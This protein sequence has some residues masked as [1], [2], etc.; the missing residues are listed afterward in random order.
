MATVV[1]FHA[2]PDARGDDA[3]R[4]AVSNQRSRSSAATSA[5]YERDVARTAYAA[6]A[7]ITHRID[8]F[9]FARQKR[10]AFAAHRTQIGDI[11]D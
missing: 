11:F 5:P 6:R 1:A 9:R 2:H 4:I 3:A 8:V 7:T 10:H